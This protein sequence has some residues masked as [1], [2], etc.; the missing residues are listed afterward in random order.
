MTDLILKLGDVCHSKRL[1]F[2]PS[3]Q[4]TQRRRTTSKREIPSHLE[5]TINMYEERNAEGL[6][7]QESNPVCFDP[8]RS[9]QFRPPRRLP[10]LD[11]RVRERA[12]KHLLDAIEKDEAKNGAD[13]GPREA[14][15]GSKDGSSSSGHSKSMKEEQDHSSS[16]E[17][18][19][20][21]E[22]S[23]WQKLHLENGKEKCSALPPDGNKISSSHSSRRV[24]L[25]DATDGAAKERRFARIA[26]KRL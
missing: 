15:T 3:L 17:E 1:V 21:T 9:P 25:Y 12:W 26:K 5:L 8:T 24:A 19:K 20:S 2:T 23:F 7:R 14:A 6:G 13:A 16:H 18:N 4:S 11:K 22:L 10:P